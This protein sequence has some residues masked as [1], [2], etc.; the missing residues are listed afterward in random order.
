MPKRTAP[1]LMDSTKPTLMTQM[2]FSWSGPGRVGRELARGLEFGR[3]ESIRRIF[4]MESAQ[5]SA[6]VVARRDLF[7]GEREDEMV[8]PCA[9]HMDRSTTQSLGPQMQ[10]LD[11][12]QARG[13]LGPHCHLHAVHSELDE[14]MVDDE[15]DG[16]RDDSPPGGGLVNPVTEHRGAERPVLEGPGGDLTDQPALVDD[17]ERQAR[18]EP[19]LTVVPATQRPEVERAAGG[20]GVARVPGAQPVSI[21]S[22]QS[23]EGATIPTPHGTQGQLPIAQ[24]Q[25]PDMNHRVIV[26][27]PRAVQ[28]APVLC[29]WPRAVQMTSAAVTSC[30][31][32][33]AGPS[34]G[35]RHDRERTDADRGTQ[36]GAAARA[37]CATP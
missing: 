6:S 12:A 2:C 27:G 7:S 9:V 22:A 33:A 32:L 31:T 3:S 11:H 34:T 25:R 29:R 17:H 15:C 23:L 30:G 1:R 4:A 26:D 8:S 24:R 14:E 21:A 10:L 28:T 13:I 35:G 19:C 5:D 16:A 20:F 18:A 36:A 37:A